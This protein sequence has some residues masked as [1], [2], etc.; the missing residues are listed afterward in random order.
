MG[1]DMATFGR[2]LAELN[3]GFLDLLAE[4][5]D[6]GL[7]DSVLRRLRTLDRPML[8]RLGGLPFGLFGFGF[9]DEAAWSVLLSPGVRDLEPGYAAADA[10]LERFTLLALTALRAL[11]RVAPRPVAAWVGMPRAT[12]VRLSALEIGLLSQ[13]ATMS[14]SRLHARRNLREAVWLRLIEAAES[15]DTRQLRLLAA[16]GRQWTIR[17]FLSIEAAVPAARGFRRPV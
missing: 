3:T 2:D 1:R 4:D 6:A 8:R 5:V 11:L 15:N 10:P 16:L 12:Q 17:R 9:E 14:A 7:S 13:V